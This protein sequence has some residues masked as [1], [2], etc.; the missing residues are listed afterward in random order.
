MAVCHNTK[1][2]IHCCG[3]EEYKGRRLKKKNESW[4]QGRGMCED[5]AEAKERQPVIS[6]LQAG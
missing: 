6:S 3:L 4:A 5:S 1:V 2:K